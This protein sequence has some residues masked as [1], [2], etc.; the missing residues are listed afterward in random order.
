ME[1]KNNYQ[2]LR[3]FAYSVL[4]QYLSLFEGSD[5][6]R[7]VIEYSLLGDGKLFRPVL[8]ASIAE[9]FGVDQERIKSIQLAVEMVHASS[10]M[11][12]DLPA[13]DDDDMRRGKPSSHKVFGEGLTLLAADYLLS[14]AS[15]EI[16]YMKEDHETIS[17]IAKS[18]NVAI[19]D[20]CEGQ[21]LDLGIRNRGKINSLEQKEL[22]SLI[23]EINLKKTGALIR[24]SLIAP[25]YLLSDVSKEDI[26]IVKRYAN[27]LS[28]L[29]QVCD[30]L[31]DSKHDTKKEEY[32]EI[33]YVD[34]LGV[35]KSN[36]Y[37]DSLVQDSIQA[38]EPLGSKADFLRYLV[39]YVRTL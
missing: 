23:Q 4:E 38:L 34:V 22:L 15:K 16:L 21:I 35:E 9:A 20:M 18:L 11:H 32:R 2:D 14:A 17:S 6:L 36:L 24:F 26:D 31:L 39:N 13:L 29:F 12:D 25:L 37:A 10:L 5:S 27:N 30:D 1:H 28:V 8:S 3:S 7:E 33:N 19:C